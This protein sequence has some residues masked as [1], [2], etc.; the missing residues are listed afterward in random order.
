M[1]YV[2]IRLSVDHEE[3][4]L[5][6]Y[7]GRI[8]SSVRMLQIRIGRFLIRELEIDTVRFRIIYI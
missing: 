8:I 7:L 3:V 6:E 4:V 2:R 5:I 1:D